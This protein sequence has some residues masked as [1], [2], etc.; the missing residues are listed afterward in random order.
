MITPY[1][2][3]ILSNKKEIINYTHNSMYNYQ[4]HLY[5]VK[6]SDS[7]GYLLYDTI[8]VTFL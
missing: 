8:Y 2:G 1:D 3:K 6:E 5:E 4:M 7:E